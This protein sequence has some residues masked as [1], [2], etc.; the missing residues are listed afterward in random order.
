[1]LEHRD[2]ILTLDREFGH[3]GFL[4]LDDSNATTPINCR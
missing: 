4:L 2:E 1:M 3:S